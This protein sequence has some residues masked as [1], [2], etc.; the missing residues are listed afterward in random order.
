[1]PQ[2]TLAVTFESPSRR[3]PDALYDAPHWYACYT[4]PRHEKKVEELLLR[5]GIESFLPVAPRVSQWKDRKKLVHFPLFSGYV[6]GC[7]TLSRLPQVLGTHGVAAVVGASGRPEPIPAAE[8]EGV[9]RVSMG[10]VQAGVG[11]ER[12]ELLHRGSWVRI[13]SGPLQGVEGMVIERLGRRRVLV[14]IRAIGEGLEVD[15][16]LAALVP[17]PTPA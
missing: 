10:A 3:A 6:F 13:D 12:A 5:Q 14:G 15:V 4:R 16:P 11:V 7:F 17:I 1:M 8:I 2:P 9:R